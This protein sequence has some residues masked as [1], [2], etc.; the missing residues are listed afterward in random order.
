VS[1]TDVSPA[2]SATD[3]RW[4]AS[5]WVANGYLWVGERKFGHRVLRYAL[6]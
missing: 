4:A 3:L 1:S 5:L 6:S 2:H